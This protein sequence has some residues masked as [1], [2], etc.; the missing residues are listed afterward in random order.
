MRFDELIKQI[1]GGLEGWQ[2]VMWGVFGFQGAPGMRG[3]NGPQ[4]PPGQDVSISFTIRGL[5]SSL[6]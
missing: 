1:C 6:S 4:G 3:F 2:N 5:G